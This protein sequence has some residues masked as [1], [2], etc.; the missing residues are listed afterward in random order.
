MMIVFLV[1]VL[2]ALLHRYIPSISG[3]ASLTSH[4]IGGLVSRV[5]RAGYRVRFADS[6][7]FSNERWTSILLE[8]L[9]DALLSKNNKIPP[10]LIYL[11]QAMFGSFTRRG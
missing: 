6:R 11:L 4:E 7:S 5:H 9:P 3:S 1:V 10:E 8:T 2:F